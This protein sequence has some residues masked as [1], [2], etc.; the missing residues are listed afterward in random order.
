MA[1][2]ESSSPSRHAQY[3]QREFS[4]FPLLGAR[5]EEA[6][7]GGEKGGAHQVSSLLR[8]KRVDTSWVKRTRN[9][10]KAVATT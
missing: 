9:I 4:N 8:T 7:L 10:A 5:T 6:Y 1:R 3:C 2:C